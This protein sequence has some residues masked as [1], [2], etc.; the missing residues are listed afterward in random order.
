MTD[1]YDIY[2]L[3]IND[4]ALSGEKKKILCPDRA[5]VA[6][7]YRKIM[8]EK[9][10]CDDLRPLFVAFP[11]LSSGK[12]QVIVDVLQDLGLIE[13]IRSDL[14]NYFAPVA[15]KEKKDLMSS[16]ILLALQ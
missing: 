6:L 12:I 3:F 8:A 13:I 1:D 16:R 4:F 7:I 14:T 5:E 10:N 15:V 9:V 2:R 11:A